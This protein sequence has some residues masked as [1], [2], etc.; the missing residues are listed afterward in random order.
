MHACGPAMSPSMWKR[1]SQDAESTGNSIL[2]PDDQ[3]GTL[4]CRPARVLTNLPSVAR[5][6]WLDK[7]ASAGNRITI[8]GP[9]ALVARAGRAGGRVIKSK[10]AAC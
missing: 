8:K 6:V 2:C 3:S 7:Q 1:E 10:Q 4:A 5:V 9:S